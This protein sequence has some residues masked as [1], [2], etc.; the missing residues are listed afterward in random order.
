MNTVGLVDG[1]NTLWGAISGVS[2]Q[3][4]TAVTVIGVALLVVAVI[5]FV[6]SKRTGRGNS[7]MLLWTIVIAALCAGPQ[8]LIPLVLKVVELLIDLVIAL[9]NAIVG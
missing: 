5:G 6:W 9:F 2:P 4:W 8:A 7:Q 3:F 1:W